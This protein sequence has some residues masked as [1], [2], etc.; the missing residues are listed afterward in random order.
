M[1]EV[2]GGMGGVSSRAGES[3]VGL[4]PTH[5]HHLTAQYQS[6]SYVQTESM[7]TAA[8]ATPKHVSRAEGSASLY[9]FNSGSQMTA[10]QARCGMGDGNNCTRRTAS[11][12]GCN[13]H[14]T[15]CV[16]GCVE[17]T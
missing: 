13:A 1:S 4:G 8:E 11:P 10:T 5:H 14:E 9:N 2:R 15:E 6:Q 17:A 12:E 16:V 3:K 7:H